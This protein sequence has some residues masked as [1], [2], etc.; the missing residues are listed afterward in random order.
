MSTKEELDELEHRFN[1]WDHTMQ[2]YLAEDTQKLI[3]IGW[4]LLRQ[5]D[6]A[7]EEAESYF[8]AGVEQEEEIARLRQLLKGFE[9]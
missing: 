8:R 5:R 3:A 7:R 9:E 1:G 2:P 6:A 4:R